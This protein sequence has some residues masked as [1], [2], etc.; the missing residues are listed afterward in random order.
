MKLVCCNSLQWHRQLLSM[1]KCI[2]SMLHARTYIYNK[3]ITI[4]DSSW[5]LKVPKFLQN[6][7][8]IFY[9]SFIEIKGLSRR[10]NGCN[11]EI[12]LNK[13]RTNFIIL[14]WCS[15]SHPLKSAP[16][17]NQRGFDARKQKWILLLLI[18]FILRFISFLYYNLSTSILFMVTLLQLYAIFGN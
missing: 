2:L 14:L 8:S 10:E 1:L 3:A 5:I 4:T 6:I 13:T 7:S 16:T 15:L 17:T 11:F 12:K 18:W 9:K